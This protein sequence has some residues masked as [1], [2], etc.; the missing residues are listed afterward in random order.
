MVQTGGELLLPDSVCSTLDIDNFLS[1]QEAVLEKNKALMKHIWHRGAIMIVKKYK[2]LRTKE[3]QR[4]LF[5]GNSSKSRWSYQGFIAEP[6]DFGYD[7]ESH[8]HEKTEQI[9][10]Q[11]KNFS[12]TGGKS[13]DEKLSAYQAYTFRTAVAHRNVQSV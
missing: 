13:A 4:M 9:I 7:L 8:M 11:I 5:P 3:Q 10:D 12:Y 1:F 6:Q 2:F